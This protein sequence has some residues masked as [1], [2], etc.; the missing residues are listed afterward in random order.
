MLEK[1]LLFLIM[2]FL[3][4]ICVALTVGGHRI[5]DEQYVMC[6]HSGAKGC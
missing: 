1:I 6:V 3:L 2:S 4:L 5:L